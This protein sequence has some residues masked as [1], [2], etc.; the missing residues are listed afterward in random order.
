VSGA[1]ALALR[2]AGRLGASGS[3]GA[4]AAGLEGWA[5]ATGA[6]GAAE[7]LGL[8]AALWLRGSGALSRGMAGAAAGARPTAIETAR[9][10]RF[11]AEPP[12]A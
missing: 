10:I 3:A 12:R 1:P 7:A 2:A 8:S 4:A 5:G 9:K 6:L 11:T